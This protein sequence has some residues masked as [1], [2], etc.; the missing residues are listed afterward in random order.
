MHDYK[1][2][3]LINSISDALGS[4]KQAVVIGLSVAR[5]SDAKVAGK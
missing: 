5:A 4:C 2:D 3:A 1:K